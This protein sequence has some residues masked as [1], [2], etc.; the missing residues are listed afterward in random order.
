MANLRLIK[1]LN[2]RYEKKSKFRDIDFD[3]INESFSGFDGGQYR[4]TFSESI[5]NLGPQFKKFFTDQESTNIYLLF[6]DICSFST[7]FRHLSNVELSKLLDDYYDLVIPIIYK[8]KGEVDKIIGDGIIAVFGEPFVQNGNLPSLVNQCAKELIT[9]TKNTVM[10]SKVAVHSGDIMYYHN[11]SMFYE[12]F[13]IIGHPVT[14]LHRLESVSTDRKINYFEGSDYDRFISGRI[15]R[16]TRRRLLSDALEPPQWVV[17]GPLS[18]SPPLK[19]V[20]GYSQR[21]TMEMV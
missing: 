1:S 15:S 20:I 18:I 6:I 16:S 21:K 19:G 5:G 2:E 8:Y 12:E 3:Q 10:Y 14:E 17:R 9:E 13:T 4:K 7:R 11:T